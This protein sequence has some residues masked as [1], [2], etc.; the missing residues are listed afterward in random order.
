MTRLER[1]DRRM[2]KMFGLNPARM[3]KAQIRRGGQLIAIITRE[4]CGDNRPDRKP[5]AIEEFEA[6]RKLV[7]EVRGQRRAPR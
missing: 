6:L 1:H 3:S 5:A 4:P 7:N 2:L